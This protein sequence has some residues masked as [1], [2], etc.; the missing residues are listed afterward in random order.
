MIILLRAAG[1]LPASMISHPLD[2][3]RSLAAITVCRSVQ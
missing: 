1:G 3:H 2:D